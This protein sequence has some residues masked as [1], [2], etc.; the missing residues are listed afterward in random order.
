L[1]ALNGWRQE[2]RGCKPTLRLAPLL[3]G[4][5]FHFLL[6]TGTLAEHLR[7]LTG[8]RKAEST[9]AGR[10][11]AL[12]WR[13]F[14]ELLRQAL[15]PLAQP[16]RQP[17]AFWRGWRLVAWD[18]TQFSLT[19][20]PQT[21]AQLRKAKSRR[22]PAAWA[23]ITAVVL[24]ELGLHN[25]LAAAIGWQGESEYALTRGLL[26]SLPRHCLL[27]A[28]RLSGVPALMAK[29]LDACLALHSH[30]LIRARN[31][32]LLLKRRRLRDGSALISVAVRDPKR[33]NKILQI[34]QLREISVYVRRG[35]HHG[36]VLRLWTSLL[37][38]RT[39]PALELARLYAQ[40]WEQE[41]YWRQMKLELRKTDLLQSHTPATAAQEIAM[42]VLA[43]ALLAHER[44]RVADGKMPV[45]QISF[46][47]CLDLLRPLWLVLGLAGKVLD[48]EAKRD[49]ARIFE[50]EIRRGLKPK[51]RARSCQ[52]RVRQPIK[53]WPRL[54]K[55]KY[56]HGEWRYKII[57]HSRRK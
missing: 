43:T 23:K 33:R 11:A 40:R 20:T 21:R 35:R 1:E 54:L 16:D 7:Q 15:R 29:I 13:I 17:E 27:L 25:P 41:L 8:R 14:V 36:E 49:L 51:R 53:G 38:P 47:K 48:S 57:A 2:Q 30:F 4:L 9:L 45:L 50:A 55:P 31:N 3:Q 28:D 22:R 39:A 19:N 5:L 18:G 26:A 37:D 52:R 24:L 10:R 6:P 32:L 56:A 34:L 44:T 42:L 46:L 12:D